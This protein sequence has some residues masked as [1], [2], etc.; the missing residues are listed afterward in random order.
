VLRSAQR[1]APAP[2]ASR[3][4]GTCAVPGTITAVDEQESLRAAWPDWATRS[5]TPTTD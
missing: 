4:A 2:S 3:V 5:P 1:S